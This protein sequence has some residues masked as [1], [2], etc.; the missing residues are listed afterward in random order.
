MAKAPPK[1]RQGHLPE[2]EPVKCPKVEK[3]ARKFLDVRDERFAIVKEFADARTNL[4][5]EMKEAGLLVYEFDGYKVTLDET[6]NVK[7]K[8]RKPAGSDEEETE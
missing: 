8:K 4:V 6:Q 3:A 1:K 2:M 5:A 7:V